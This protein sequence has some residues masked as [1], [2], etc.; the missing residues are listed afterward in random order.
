MNI[1]HILLNLKLQYIVWA[2]QMYF[3]ENLKPW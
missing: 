2:M 3:L 1:E